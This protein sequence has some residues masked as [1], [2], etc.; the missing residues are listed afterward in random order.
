MDL[1]EMLEVSMANAVYKR[2]F[3]RCLIL[4]V[5]G[6]TACQGTTPSVPTPTSPEEPNPEAGDSRTLIYC[7]REDPGSL[8]LYGFGEGTT[9]PEG[10]VLETIYDGPIDNRSF[11]FQPVILEK[12]PSL[13]DSDAQLGPVAVASGD[14]IVDAAGNPVI[15][16]AGM[17]VRPSGCQSDECAIEFD[18]SPG[19]QMDQLSATFQLLPDLLWSD[20]EP[21]TAADSVYS[22]NL[23]ADPDTPVLADSSA[24]KSIIERTASYA[25]MDDRTVEWVSLP[26]FLD[27]VYFTNFWNPLPEHL[28]GELSAAELL[29]AE[30]STQKPVGWGPYVIEERVPG[31]SIVFRKNEHYFRA[32]E[33]L[34]RFD[35]LVLRFVGDDPSANLARLLSGECDLVDRLAMNIE[36]VGSVERLFELST[37]GQISATFTNGSR[38]EHLDFGIQPVDYDDGWQAGDR[39][40]FFGDVR[41]RRAFALC[42][43]RPRMVEV[44]SFGQ[45]FV[46]DSYLSPQHPLYNSQVMHYDFDPEAGSALLEEVGWVLGEDGV[47]VFAAEHPR[48]PLGTRLS[49]TTDARAGV[50]REAMQVM[51][52]SLVECGIEVKISYWDGSELFADGPEGMVFGRNF[53]LTVFV[54]LTGAAPPC[55]LYLSDQIPGEETSVFPLGWAGQNNPG[56]SDPAYDRACRAAQQSL[57]G[58]PGYAENHLLAQQIFA[59]QLP[60]IPLYFVTNISTTRPDFCGQILDP[61]ENVDSWNVEAFDYGPDC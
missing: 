11:D 41:T 35:R 27:S 57:P 25:A 54:W 34:P 23:A 32:G 14:Q 38:F 36:V 16:E 8:Y 61:S 56:F 52:D 29:T 48:I 18:G 10:V 3:L 31:E 28:W 43:D 19:L 40:D 47:R 7:T 9:L 44:A 22:F 46:P 51:V 37:G 58:Q 1:F 39:P 55:E 21:L 50:S 13:A 26:G 5:F 20:G 15:L 60:V 59:E 53:D 24:N 42:L 6:L 2:Y 12:L 49:I 17:R 33:G 45:S 30:I 4:L